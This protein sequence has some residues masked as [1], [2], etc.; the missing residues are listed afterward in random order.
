M[1]TL[2]AGIRTLREPPD[3]ANNRNGSRI[4][5]RARRSWR[6]I[7][8]S[9]KELWR[10]AAS[11]IDPAKTADIRRPSFFLRGPLLCLVPG[12]EN[13]K[14]NLENRCPPI[15]KRPLGDRMEHHLHDY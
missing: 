13:G 15:D 1:E 12:S 14:N 7:T 3:L 2:V 10:Q 11:G 4:M 9:G 6:R 8:S 5:T